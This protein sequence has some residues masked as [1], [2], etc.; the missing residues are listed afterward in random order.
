MN[1][2]ATI[3]YI[4][5]VY[6]RIK[7][8]KLKWAYSAQIKLNLSEVNM[9]INE[10]Y[11][12]L[13]ESYLFSTIAKKVSDFSSKKPNMEI[14]KLGIGDVTLPLCSAVI[15][16]LHNAVNEM[17]CKET[18]KGY[19]PEQGHDFLKI[20]IQNYY[21]NFCITLKTSLKLPRTNCCLASSSPSSL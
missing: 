1:K 18:F 16:E 20:S 2:G 13:N 14:I 8:T 5:N 15:E 12:N 3:Y 21:K 6:A 17:S 11:K 4:L 7:I 10:N 9:N 19:G